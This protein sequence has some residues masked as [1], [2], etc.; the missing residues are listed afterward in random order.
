MRKPSAGGA[1][2]ACIS[3]EIISLRVT[4]PANESR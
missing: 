3:A 2:I 1:A 4:T